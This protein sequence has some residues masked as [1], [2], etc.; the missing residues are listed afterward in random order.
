M[1]IYF[2]KLAYRN[3]YRNK[4]YTLINAIGLT[5]GLSLS[6]VIFS[7]IIFEL[8][9]DQFHKDYDRIYRLVMADEGS[10][11][12]AVSPAV[13]TTILDKIPEIESS[14]RIFN[15]D[16]FGKISVDYQNQTYTDDRI[17]FVDPEFFDIFSFPLIHGDPEKVLQK[18]NAAVITKRLARKY[19]G[20][21]DPTGKTLKLG[22]ILLVEVTGILENV[23]AQSHFHFDMLVSMKSHPWGPRIE[24][25]SL[26]SSWMFHT[27]FKVYPGSS[28][29]TVRKKC[30]RIGSALVAE[31]SP[32]YHVNLILQPLTDIHL[33]SDY[34][35]ELEANHDIRYIYLFGTVALLVILIAGIN[36]INLTTAY[37]FGRAKEVGLKKVMGAQ[38]YQLFIQHLGE[39]FIIS[40]LALCISLLFIELIQPVITGLTGYEYGS[41]VGNSQLVLLLIGITAVTGL[42]SGMVP[43]LIIS[44]IPPRRILRSGPQLS[45]KKGW[46]RKILVIFQLCISL[47]LLMAVA[48]IYQQLRYMQNTKLGYDKSHVVVLYTGYRGFK[49]ANFKNTLLSESGIIHATGI[50][51]LPSDIKSN[52]YIDTPDG[53]EHWIYYTSIDKDFFKTLDVSLMT[54]KEEIENLNPENYPNRYVVNEAAL[55]EIGWEPGEAISQQIRIRHGNMEPGPVIGVIEDFHFQSLHFPVYPL[56]LEFVPNDYH[57]LLVKIRGDRLQETIREIEV[58][59]KKMAGNLPFEYS[60]LDQEYDNLYKAEMKTGK[61]FILFA[62]FSSLIAMMGLFGLASYTAFK[63]TK[64]IGIRKVFGATTLHILEL[65]TGDFTRLV[66]IAFVISVPLAWFLLHKWL[67]EFAYRV[68]INPVILLAA[69]LLVLLLTLITV[70]YHSVKAAQGDPAKTLR[71]E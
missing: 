58:Q 42:L 43:S 64:E 11:S 41:L 4:L 49:Q 22:D 19:F 66:I 37:S 17:F 3:L 16:Q 53:K 9:F 12:V 70:G 68:N 38:K 26:G 33:R 40:F 54:G 50:S 14:V 5:I 8:H 27:Y 71:Y 20:D 21:D 69:G 51:S 62:L 45:E 35:G 61:L 59:W 10:S 23:P 55:K 48:V 13:K 57:Y 7:W 67:E 29:E 18:P 36:Y 6:F 30:N 32:H 39:S 60:F 56:V 46:V 24:E 25:I 34:E 28:P 31:I 52:E 47:L 65:L 63:R 15:G 2:F 1:L 44:S